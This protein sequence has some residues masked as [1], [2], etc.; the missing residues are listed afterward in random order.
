MEILCKCNGNFRSNPL[1][2]ENWSTSEGRPLIP[3]NYQWIRASNL[4]FNRL[5]RKFW[6][7]GK[8]P[9][10]HPDCQNVVEGDIPEGNDEPFNCNTVRG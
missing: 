7:N 4:H 9:W 6:L 8:R 5:K 10:F 2:G 3:E 1:E